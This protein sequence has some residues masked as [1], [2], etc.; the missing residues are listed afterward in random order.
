MQK[1]FII[2]KM[3]Q[4]KTNNQFQNQRFIKWIYVSFGIVAL[5]FII[6][7][8][9]YIYVGFF[10]RYWYDDFCT[11]GILQ[12]RGFIDSQIYWYTN[13]SGRFSFH[14][15]VNIAELIGPKIV[16]ILPLLVISAWCISATWTI[17]QL[18]LTFRLPFA[19]IGSFVLALAVVFS[20]LGST[21][22]IVQSLYWQTGMLTY[23]AP[24][25]LLTVWTGLLVFVSRIQSKLLVFI[26]FLLIGFTLCFIAGGL[27]ETYGILQLGILIILFITGFFCFCN[28]IRKFSL[29]FISASLLGAVLA[30]SIVFFAPGNEGRQAVLPKSPS[31]VSVVK[32]SILYTLNFAERHSRR[33]RGIAL[34]SF[35]F[36]AWLVL[37]FYGEISDGRVNSKITDIKM[38]SALKII[39]LC[40]IVGFC[41]IFICFI[42]AFYALSETLPLRAQILPKFIL[43]TF[44][45]FV[46]FLLMLSFLNSYADYLRLKFWTLIGTSI[47]LT[48]LLFVPLASAKRN[49]SLGE[50]AA[51]YAAKWD[52]IER[53]ISAA[54]SNGQNNV[55]IQNINADEFELGFGRAD[56]LPTTKP[57]E[58]QNICLARYFDLDSIIAK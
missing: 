11:A 35:L 27:S 52:E 41:L 15:I 16:T 30:F 40:I 43:V 3:T 8:A 47:A 22:D 50:K 53:E 36:P 34:L 46:G 12:Q 55:V 14:I 5:V 29:A 54:K 44:M 37:M 58:G 48:L 56:M 19:L 57:T 6:A 1:K 20:T 31:K 51:V 42:P 28:S 33:S 23:L 7:L 13:W 49:L 2:P 18:F 17:H 4:T 26:L 39:G 24:L 9:S 45:M 38:K 25:V 10:T 32:S 21:P